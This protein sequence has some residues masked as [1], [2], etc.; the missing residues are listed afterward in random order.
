M[1]FLEII[2][3]LFGWGDPPL[4]LLDDEIEYYPKP[5]SIY[6]RYGNTI[7]INSYGM[8]SNEFDHLNPG[9]FHV[10]IFGD[11]VVYGNHLLDQPETIAYQLENK[12]QNKLGVSTIVSAIAASSWG[13]QNI[14]HFYDKKGP[15]TGAYAIIIQSSHDRFDVI[16]G[17]SLSIKPPYRIDKSFIAIDDFIERIWE[18]LESRINMNNQSNKYSRAEAEKITNASLTS[19]ISKL[20][21]SY[22]HVALYYH[23]T[24]SELMKQ[25]TD[26]SA[27][28][29]QTLAK[30]E[31][32]DFIDSTIEYQKRKCIKPIYED[33]IH[34]TP[35]GAFCVSE[36]IYN[37]ISGYL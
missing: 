28:Y 29:Y 15:F 18:W 31:G 4:A 37:W 6:N 24:N 10:S 8:R 11:S 26:L 21:K 27:S 16:N 1:V 32:I 19:L 33:N 35:K 3:R 9:S 22:G 14:E 17:S 2:L 36:I 25:G 20:K 12:I 23:S 34:L 7:K 13:P 30:E 5:S